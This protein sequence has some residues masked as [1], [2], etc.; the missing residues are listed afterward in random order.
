MIASVS[1]M[2]WFH[3]KHDHARCHGMYRR[4]N[5]TSKE[6]IPQ[7]DLKTNTVG[8]TSIP[9]GQ[10]GT[11]TQGTRRRNLP[12]NAHA[13]VHALQVK[14]HSSRS[15]SNKS[16]VLASAISN[17]DVERAEDPFSFAGKRN[18]AGG[19]VSNGRN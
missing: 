7:D 17:D 3:D 13:H 1:V 14:Q 8:G 11:N 2:M 16:Q 19:G 6:S 18:L 9:V 5:G 10:V 12:C 4:E 15:S